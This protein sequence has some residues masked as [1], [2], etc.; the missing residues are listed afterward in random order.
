MAE[1]L[2]CSRMAITL[3]KVEGCC[4]KYWSKTLHTQW[5][6]WMKL[7]A[8]VISIYFQFESH[9]SKW[10]GILD[11]Y[12][13]GYRVVLEKNSRRTDWVLPGHGPLEISENLLLF[14][15]TDSCYL[16]DTLRRKPKSTHHE[17][18]RSPSSTVTSSRT[19]KTQH[20][21]YLPREMSALEKPLPALN[22][23]HTNSC[24][25]TKLQTQLETSHKTTEENLGKKNNLA[26][27]MCIAMCKKYETQSNRLIANRIDPSQRNVRLTPEA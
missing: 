24:I 23:Q 1:K 15:R 4:N 20:L 12:L 22:L 19:T 26:Q 10:V 14:G 8:T 3:K 6:V 18:S 11:F 16:L 5:I 27:P 25:E 17:T 2:Q 9:N 7:L 21:L 13:D